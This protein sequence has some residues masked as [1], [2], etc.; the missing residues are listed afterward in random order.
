MSR[1]TGSFLPAMLLGCLALLA[2]CGGS[3]STIPPPGC[4]YCPAKLRSEMGTLSIQDEEDQAP[5]DPALVTAN[6][7]FG[8]AVLNSLLSQGVSG[9][10][11]IAPMSLA[12][13]LE[14]AY[15]GADGT[16]QQAMAQVLQLGGLTTQQ[17][18]SDNT[19]L[20]AALAALDPAVDLVIQGQIWGNFTSSSL[21]GGFDQTLANYYGPLTNALTGLSPSQSAYDINNDAAFDTYALVGNIL[22]SA[23]FT[24]APDGLLPVSTLYF[25]GTWHFPFPPAQTVAATFTN[26]AGAQTS[27]TRMALTATLPYLQGSNFQAI[28]LPYGADSRLAMLVVLPNVGTSVNTFV[29][30]VTAATIG[31]W[32]SE[33]QPEAVALALPR[34]TSSY[35]GSLQGALTSAGM[36]AAFDAVNAGFPAFFSGAYLQDVLHGTVLSVNENGTTVAAPT[37]AGP[38]GISVPPPVN[39]NMV[40]DH[41]FFYAIRDNQT[42]ELLAI[43]VVT[44]PGSG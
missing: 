11:S 16:T 40:V 23:T 37:N 9:N 6:N 43:G 27:A 39:F 7:D 17:L 44:D 41:P 3:N 32:A 1:L 34:F 13:V 38:G 14:A 42:G 31:Q 19:A 12:E 4:N 5:V 33:L 10:P 22:G 29:A 26:S 20:Q 35:A 8:L 21:P 30:S 36:G 25:Q 28:S 18:N 15:N 24:L 2:G